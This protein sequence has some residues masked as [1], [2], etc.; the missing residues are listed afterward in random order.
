MARHLD[1]VLGS[2]LC[3]RCP[4]GVTGCSAA[5]PVVAWADLGRNARLGG[6]AWI[7]AELEAARLYP[8][9]RG[10]AL[11]RVPNPDVASTGRE[12]KCVYHGE[13]GCT[14]PHDRRSA[15]CNYYLCDDAAG[16]RV[17]L[18]DRLTT[19]YGEWDL[20]LAERVRARFPEGPPWDV[21][22]LEWLG[23]ELARLQIKRNRSSRAHGD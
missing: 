8:C 13:M 3:A 6:A 17:E 12:K 20:I 5:P 15:T 19:L 21:S 9:A 11:Q 2:E 23:V 7:A 14:I 16:D 1:V 10:L 22:F 18:R 4:Q